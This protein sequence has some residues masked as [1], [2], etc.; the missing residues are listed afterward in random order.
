MAEDPNRP[1]LPLVN[2]K[3]RRDDYPRDA[4]SVAGYI[5]AH[6]RTWCLILAGIVA[7]Q[8][9]GLREFVDRGRFGHHH[10]EADAEASTPH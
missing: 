2:P 10:L 8:C 4:W 6:P 5:L 1:I 7:W 3:Q 9:M